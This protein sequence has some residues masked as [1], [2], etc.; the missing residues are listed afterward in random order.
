[1]G[2]DATLS[3]ERRTGTDQG[4]YEEDRWVNVRKREGDNLRVQWVLYVK[5]NQEGPSKGG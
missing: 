2:V 5:S 1:M 4:R 3:V